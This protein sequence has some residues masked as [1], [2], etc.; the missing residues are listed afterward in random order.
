MPPKPQ[1]YFFQHVFKK[2]C[3]FIMS[4]RYYNSVPFDLSLQQ[5]QALFQT[6][7]DGLTQK[8]CHNLL[9]FFSPVPLNNLF[10]LIHLQIGKNITFLLSVLILIALSIGYIMFL[11]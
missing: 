7:C 5:K 1:N 2:L 3:F 10:S 6:F 8:L 4:Q 9:Y 11:K